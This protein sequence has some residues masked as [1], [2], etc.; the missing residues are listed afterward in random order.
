MVRPDPE[1]KVSRAASRRRNNGIGF[2]VH[3]LTE[4][5]GRDEQARE[6]D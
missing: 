6:K 1:E 3:K 5:E 4:Q 2:E